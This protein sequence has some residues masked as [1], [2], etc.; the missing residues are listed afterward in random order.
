VNTLFLDA[1][2]CRN[3]RRPPV[4]LMRQAGRYLPE[5]RALRASHSLLELFHT[6]QLAAAVTRLPLDRLGVDAAIL[7]S[8]ILVIAEAFGGSLHFEDGCKPRVV[9]PPSPRLRSVRETLAYVFE[10]IR[11]LKKTL[12]VPLIGF[13]GGPFTVARYAELPLEEI[14]RASIEYLLLQIEA[15]V[16]AVQLFDTWAGELG[17]EAFAA[18]CSDH[19]S[20]ILRALEPTHVPVVVFCKGASRFLGALGQL[21]LRAIS[22]DAEQEMQQLRRLVPP[23]VAVQGNLD[24]SLLRQAPSHIQSEVLRLLE[25]MQGERGF[26]VNLGHGVP[27]DVPVAH[28]KCFVDTVL[29]SH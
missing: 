24:P 21:P 9:L 5:Y 19:L 4:W 1:L 15:G 6:P 16:D 10:T 3:T 18:Y 27:P 29:A 14:T 23:S 22:F 17:A 8:D 28:V 20:K 12:T 25:S 13:C 7:F 11:L 2:H 26:I